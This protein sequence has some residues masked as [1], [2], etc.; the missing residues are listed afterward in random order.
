M[1]TDDAKDVDPEPEYWTEPVRVTPPRYWTSSPA[2][3]WTTVAP[4][5]QIRHTRVSLGEIEVRIKREATG[6]E[7]L[8]NAILRRLQTTG[9]EVPPPDA[10]EANHRAFIALLCN[11]GMDEADAVSYVNQLMGK[12]S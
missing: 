6:V 10:T 11:Q 8:G 2:Q 7:R 12:P 9:V 5:V 4:G 1:A 3:G